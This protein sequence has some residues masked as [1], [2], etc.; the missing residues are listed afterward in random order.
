MKTH[1]I[2]ASILLFLLGL[3]SVVFS[4]EQRPTKQTTSFKVP[5]D[6][7]ASNPS[8]AAHTRTSDQHSLETALRYATG[9]M[10]YVQ[11][12][13]QDYTCTLVK[14]ERID[15]DLQ[16]PQYIR[17]FVRAGRNEAGKPVPLSVFLEY[18]APAKVKGRKVLYVAGQNDNQ[19]LVRNGGKRFNYVTVKVDPQSEAAL[20]ESRAPITEIGFENMT[21]TFVRLIQENIRR[22]PNSANTKLTFF[23]AAKVNDRIC[24]RVLVVHPTADPE[25]EFAEVDVYVDDELHVPIRI[26]GYDWP[27]RE[28]QPM[29]LL[30]EYTYE[31]LQINVGLTDADFSPALLQPRQVANQR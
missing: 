5:T 24:T 16:N 15:G 6:K 2:F 28:G 1:L 29:P 14:R 7:V 21:R 13:V 26:E 19:M 4:Q 23:K 17:A 12:H 27:K 20:R 3:C 8:A 30:F 31:D 9:V 11:R 25:L 18:V 22:D 10:N